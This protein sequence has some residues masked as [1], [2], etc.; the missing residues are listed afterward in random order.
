MAISIRL[1][2]DIESR[3]DALARE[4]GRTKTQYVR[5][6]I[7]RFLEDEEDYRLALARLEKPGNRMS[8]DEVKTRLGL[9]D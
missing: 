7:I 8:L 2:Q 6:A 3:L 9:E 1:D 5:E 4:T